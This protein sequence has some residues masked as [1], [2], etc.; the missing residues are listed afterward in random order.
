VPQPAT[1][2]PIRK[3]RARIRGM[4]VGRVL[5][6]RSSRMALTRPPRGG[7]ES[8]HAACNTASVAATPPLNQLTLI[9]GE[10]RFL[11]DRSAREWRDRARPAQLDI[12]VFDAP[13]RLNDLRLA[14]AEMPLLDPE[15]A[16]LL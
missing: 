12:E 3:P 13:G 1:S 8:P 14:V 15:R 7:S 4:L 10:E 6:A 2:T 9:H 11:V 16:L 5:T